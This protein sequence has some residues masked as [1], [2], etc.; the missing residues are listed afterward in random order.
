MTQPLEARCRDLIEALDLGRAS[1]LGE[2]KPLTGGVASDIAAVR[3]GG[4]AYCVKFA[5]PKLKVAADWFAPVHRNAAEYAWLQVAAD[6]VPQG[7]IRLFGR[8]E[9]QHGFAMEL[10]AGDDVYLWKTAMLDGA[11]LR[12]EAAAV[13]EIIGRI[14]AASAKAGFDTSTFRN[15]DDFRALRIEPYLTFTAG[16]HPDVAAELTALADMLYQSDA[17]LV[18]GDVSPK[19]ILIRDGAPVILDAECATM[20][21]A[22]FDPAFCLNHLVL[23]AVHLPPQRAELLDAIGQFWGAYAAHITWEDAA[24]LEARVCRLLPALMLARI[25]GKSPVEYLVETRREQVRQLALPLIAS[26]VPTLAGFANELKSGLE[27]LET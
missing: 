26:P 11:P 22:S 21:D 15:R 5:L 18:H 8:S 27:E 20:G 14:H 4:D 19:N 23:K 16:A 7:A 1:D 9:E 25:D 2:V 17:V 10:I 24:E 3:V 6:V 12:G 13:G